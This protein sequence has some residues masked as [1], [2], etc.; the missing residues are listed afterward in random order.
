MRVVIVGGGITGL[1]AAHR[2]MELRQE[3]S[4]PLDVRLLE[5]RDRLGGSI[6]TRRQDGFLIEEG[7]DAFLSQKPWALKLCQ[8]IGIADQLIQT[9]ETYR[10]TFVVH[11]GKLHPVPEG[12]YMLAPTQFAPFVRSPLFSWRGKVRMAMDLI[13]PRGPKQEDESLASFVLRRLGREA[14]ERVAQPLVSGVYTSDPQRLSLRTTMPRFLEMEEKHRSI[15]W[16]MWRE[17]HQQRVNG[18]TGQ[19]E[20]GA[21]YSLFVSFKDGMATLIDALAARLPE[22]VVRL[23]HRVESLLPDECGWRLTVANGETLKADGVIITTPAH[24][25]ATLVRTFDPV[26]ASQLADIQYASSVVVNLAY[27]RSDVPH[28]LDGFGFVVPAIEKR[29]LIACSFSSVKFAGRAPAGYALLRCFL[30]GGIQPEIYHLDDD[31]LLD[32][33]RHEMRDLLGIT[34]PPLFS[35]LSRHPQS[36]PQYAVGHLQRVAHIRAQV[37]NHRGLFLAGNAY[38]GVGI[39]DCVRSGE[40]AAEKLA[41]KFVGS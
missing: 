6:A 15:I 32:A 20:S 25:A 14:L 21:R 37:E 40:E 2:L 13:L 35:C 3:K 33:V 41:G 26:L 24:H 38:G 8:R 34:A 39:P 16:A 17:R 1:A 22:G 23:N 10:R 36:M 9:N 18:A 30:G 7:P 27:R 12:F 31:A 11:R 29:R 19:R 5:A 28:P 4:L